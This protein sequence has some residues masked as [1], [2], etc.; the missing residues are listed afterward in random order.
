MFG[1]AVH[2]T[3]EEPSLEASWKIFL[4]SLGIELGNASFNLSFGTFRPHLWLANEQIS[5][6]IESY[7]NK[8][9]AG[10]KPTRYQEVAD[11]SNFPILCIKGIALPHRYSV[12]LFA[13]RV[14]AHV[15][16]KLYWATFAEGEGQKLCLIEGN[17]YWYLQNSA[18]ID[19]TAALTPQGHSDLILKAFDCANS[20]RLSSRE[21][22]LS[23]GSAE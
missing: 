3:F 8:D 14:K 20:T 5:I 15:Y 7:N 6:E 1:G 16:P 22:L 2:S 18:L 10:G 11:Q 21:S 23:C 13:P 19:S 9:R 17:K 4:L 12:R